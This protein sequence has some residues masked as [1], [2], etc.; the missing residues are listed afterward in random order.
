[1]DLLFAFFSLTIFTM[2]LTIGV[3]QSLGHLISLWQQPALLFRSLLA[4]VV[5]V[6]A[7]V[8][9]LLWFFDLSPAVATGLAIL[10]AA[11]G[12][13]LTTK[14]SEIAAADPV[15]TTSLQLALALLAILVTPLIL[16]IFYASFSLTTEAVSPIEVAKQIGKVTFLPVII[17][18]SLQHFAPKL[19]ATISK[20]LNI[21][22]T[23]LLALLVLA[24]TV[25]IVIAPELRAGLNV[26]GPALVAILIMAIAAV[27]IGHLL[28][29]DNPARR[30]GLAVASVA[31]NIGLA[32]YILGLT[33]HGQ[34]VAPTVL[35]FLL[36]G[37]AVAVPYSLWIKR[38]IT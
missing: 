34:E 20:P 2:M 6:P 37:L 17:G 5:L 10:A 13:P 15:Y 32:L 9:A 25:V 36:V 18:L 14:R 31:R 11:P 12:A 22:A 30:G 4:V 28:G 29:G 21:L 16:A 24:V 33:D 3:N 19:V 23:V 26:G 7:V 8:F 27:A 38:Q 1:M 35:V